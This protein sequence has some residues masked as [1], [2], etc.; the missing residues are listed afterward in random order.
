MRWGKSWAGELGWVWRREGTLGVCP[1]PPGMWKGQFL[2]GK[3]PSFLLP[4]RSGLLISCLP[5]SWHPVPVPLCLLFINYFWWHLPPYLVTL[6]LAP[7]AWRHDISQRE[8]QRPAG[9]PAVGVVRLA[10]IDRHGELWQERMWA[11]PN[12]IL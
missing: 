10:R 2:A 1:Q 7:A 12:P 6:L 11:P 9:S 3:W 4:A 5:G 8:C